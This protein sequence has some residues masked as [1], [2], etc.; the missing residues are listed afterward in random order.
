MFRWTWTL[1]IPLDASRDTETHPETTV[2]IPDHLEARSETQAKNNYV[3]YISRC[4]NGNHDP[5]P[6]SD[7]SP[8]QDTTVDT[9]TDAVEPEMPTADPEAPSDL[10]VH[11]DPAARL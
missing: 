3:R 4:N 7:L 10:E 2:A 5:S 9:D 6:D 1:W 8:D 11:F